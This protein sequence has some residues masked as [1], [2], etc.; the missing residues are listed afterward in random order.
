M[1]VERENPNKT[2]YL[3]N[4]PEG[5]STDIRLDKYITSFVQN[6]SRNKVQKAIKDGHVLV[7]GKLEKSSYIMQPGDKIEIS[8]P[9]PPSPEAKPE[10]IPL[11]IIYEDDDLIVVNKEEGMVV[12]PAFGN[13]TGTM[14]NGLLYHAD[15]LS[16]EDE[17]TVRPGIVHRLDKDTS[18]LLVVAKNEVAHKKLSAQ[19]AE[20][21]VERTYW[22]I[23]WGNPPDS[24]T[25]EGNIGRSP[26]DRKI[27]TVLKEKKGKSAVTHFET[28]ERFDH[29][30]LLKIN[31][32]TGRTHQIRVHMQH[33]NYYVFGDPTYG[34]DS[35]RY[36]PNTGSRKAMF[37]NLFARLER[38]ALHAKTLG[39]IHPAT[40]KYVEFNSTL[41]EDF[42]FVLDTLRTN[43][44]P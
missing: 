20:K 5:Q 3:L 44:K 32:E 9:I 21:S 8:L 35:V 17:E 12:H 26:R 14:V 34:G 30:A 40:D 31:L 25:I 27:M 11:D 16:K 15:T 19:F 37:N 42:Q 23:V 18:G 7:N 4:V 43:C 38:Q 36:G 41:P 13:W 28:I 39:F 24:G 22:A 29:L 33:Q 2:E 1:L 6:A 10:D